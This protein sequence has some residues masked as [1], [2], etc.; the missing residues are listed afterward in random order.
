MKKTRGLGRGARPHKLRPSNVIA[1]V[2]ALAVLFVMLHTSNVLMSDDKG[3][4]RLNADAAVD[5]EDEILSPV[6]KQPDLKKPPP[7]MEFS[8][9]ELETSFTLNNGD[10]YDWTSA[11]VDYGDGLAFIHDHREI[12]GPEGDRAEEWLRKRCRGFDLKRSGRREGQCYESNHHPLVHDQTVCTATKSD[13]YHAKNRSQ[14]AI[15]DTHPL[16]PT[17]KYTLVV[18]AFLRITSLKKSMAIYARCPDVSSYHIVWGNPDEKP[19]SRDLVEHWLQSSKGREDLKIPLHIHLMA[20]DS[21]NNRYLDLPGIL[22][23]AIVHIDD[24]QTTGCHEMRLMHTVWRA[25]PQQLVGPH[26]RAFSCW[27]RDLRT[28]PSVRVKEESDIKGIGFTYWKPIE[29]PFR[30]YECALTKF[31]E[32]HRCFSAAFSYGLLDH[33]THK[34]GKDMVDKYLNGEDIYFQATA[35]FLTGLGPMF[36]QSMDIRDHGVDD[37]QGISTRQNNNHYQARQNIV[38]EVTTYL[39]FPWVSSDTKLPKTLVTPDK[40]CP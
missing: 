26:I 20:R 40:P 14:W 7:A 28:N 21:L 9:S 34:D 39:G 5:E 10:P 17:T 13:E 22:T 32:A 4:Q 38:K 25:Y 36:I 27:G 23:D 12:T 24:D 15:S 37:K 2:I 31:A 33:P 35:S 19:P 11:L 16:H 8:N 18:P 6:V 29:D 30:G 3:S 1:G